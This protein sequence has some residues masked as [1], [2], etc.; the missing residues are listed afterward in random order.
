MLLV[1]LKVRR[2]I[3][4][5]VVTMLP[6]TFLGQDADFEFEFG[7]ETTWTDL[8]SDEDVAGRVIKWVNV[9]TR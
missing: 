1:V 6:I 9:N 8:I 4:F 2:S 3:L 7:E 5:V